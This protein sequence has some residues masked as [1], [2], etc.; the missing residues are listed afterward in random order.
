M[1]WQRSEFLMSSV[2]AYLRWDMTR[3]NDTN[4]KHGMYSYNMIDMH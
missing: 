4:S 1:S 2:P 3:T